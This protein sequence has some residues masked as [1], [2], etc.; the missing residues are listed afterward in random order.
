MHRPRGGQTRAD[1]G[2]GFGDGSGGEDRVG[3]DLEMGRQ[4]E[5][6]GAGGEGG[7][8][9]LCGEGLAS[10]HSEGTLAVLELL[11]RHH[12][13]LVNGLTVLKHT[14]KKVS[15]PVQG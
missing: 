15:S 6:G 14:I 8:F 9:G 10:L 12:E 5:R 7:S 1:R 4:V 11:L 13:D 3:G 2:E